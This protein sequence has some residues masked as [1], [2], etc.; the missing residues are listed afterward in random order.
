MRFPT[1]FSKATGVPAAPNLTTA[2][3][4]FNVDIPKDGRI[5]NIVVLMNTMNAGATQLQGY[6][7]YDAT[8]Q[9]P[10][11]PYMTDTTI[12]DAVTSVGG[13]VLRPNDSDG[14]YGYQH[15]HSRDGSVD[16]GSRATMKVTVALRVNATTA[17]VTDIIVNGL[18]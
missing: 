7:S 14:L 11:L 1:Q 18:A 15:T 16:E 10:L 8:G 9:K 6:V 17:I 2:Y 3:A 4:F 13:A 12:R 5:D